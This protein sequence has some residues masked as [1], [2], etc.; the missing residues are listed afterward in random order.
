[1]KNRI[2]LLIIGITIAITVM[3]YGFLSQSVKANIGNTIFEMFPD[4]NLAQVVVDEVSDGNVKCNIK[5]RYVA[6]CIN[7]YAEG[8]KT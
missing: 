1:M 3:T 5:S 4:A 2:L 6:S 7:L 8:F